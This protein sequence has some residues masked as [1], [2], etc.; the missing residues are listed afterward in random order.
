LNDKVNFYIGFILV[1]VTTSVPL[2]YYILQALPKLSN[3]VT[4]SHKVAPFQGKKYKSESVKEAKAENGQ[5]VNRV[6]FITEG[7]IIRFIKKAYKAN[8]SRLLFVICNCA[9]F[10]II[11]ENL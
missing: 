10:V 11:T 4:R 8:A 1:R 9:V 7:L 3:G 5:L 6:L 2:T